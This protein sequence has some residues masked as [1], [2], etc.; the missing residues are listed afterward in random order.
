MNLQRFF[1]GRAIGFVILLV[2]VFGYFY[3]FK[4]DK[5]K[6]IG[7]DRDTNGCLTS[8]GFAW[9]PDVGA[10]IRA[11]EMTPD[12]MKAGKIAVDYVGRFYAL[13]IV[14]F[15]SY[16]EV[17][18]YD[19]FFEIGEDREKKTVFI[20]DGKVQ[21]PRVVKLYYYNPEKDKDVTGNIMCSRDGLVS[22]N[23]EIAVSKTPIEDTIRLL[24]LGDLSEKEKNEGTSTEYPLSGFSLSEVNL[25]NKVLTLKFED[26]ENKT[27]GGTCRVGVLWFQIEATAK[28]F[29]EVAEVRFLPEDIFQ[30]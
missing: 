13:T 28:Q 26:S 5:Q 27:V 29:P 4:N 22:V 18:A 16:E 2:V 3:F 7:G 17:G 11:F 19:I 24:L 8:A 15:N 6:P 25:K 23:R 14:S 20:R 21:L 1:V 12:I 9:S 10:C 30:P